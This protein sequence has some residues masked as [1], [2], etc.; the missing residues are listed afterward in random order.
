MADNIVRWTGLGGLF[1]AGLGILVVSWMGVKARTV[2]I[3]TRRA[4]GATASDIF[5]QILFEAVAVSALG[6]ALGLAAGW[7]SSRLIAGQVDLPFVFDW[8]NASFA[9]AYAI[10]L[11]LAF[12]L[13]PSRKA[14]RPDPIR[15]LKYE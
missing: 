14:S 7:Q 13:L 6:S 11:N 3:G 9:F 4:L 10:T 15:A 8:G 5:F 2:E 12:A 1:V